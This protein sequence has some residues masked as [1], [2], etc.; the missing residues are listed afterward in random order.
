MDTGDSACIAEQKVCIHVYE[1]VS[2][3]EC[4]CEREAMCVCVCVCAVISVLTGTLCVG[5]M[6]RQ[7]SLC[8][9][10]S[11]GGMGSPPHAYR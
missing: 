8:L 11:V 4:V 10:L 2:E 5:D 3:R 7:S 1:S 6:S 9:I